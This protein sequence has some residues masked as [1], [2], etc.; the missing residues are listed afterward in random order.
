MLLDLTLRVR[1][2]LKAAG[3][4][5]PAVDLGKIAALQNIREIRVEPLSVAGE[6]RRLKQGGY[7]VTLSQKASPERRRFTLAHEIGHT[8]LLED[9]RFANGGQCGAPS[10]GVEE[11]CNFVASELLIPD[12]LIRR[13]IGGQPNIAGHCCPV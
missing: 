6:L 9:P 8:L 5:A 2:L 1:Q 11:L 12:H 3:A 13:K 7:V 10:D 4:A